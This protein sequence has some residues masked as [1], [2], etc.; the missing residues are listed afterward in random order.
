MPRSVFTDKSVSVV[1]IISQ[2]PSMIAKPIKELVNSPFADV[3]RPGLPEEII[4]ITPEMVTA[5]MAATTRMV[6]PQSR[7]PLKPTMRWQSVQGSVAP[8]PQ[9]TSPLAAEAKR[10]KPKIMKKTKKKEMLNSDFLIN[11]FCIRHFKLFRKSFPIGT[12][13]EAIVFSR[14]VFI[15]IKRDGQGYF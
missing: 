14:S 12:K 10:K 13:A 11:I 4:Y 5:V 3:I 6:I 8:V 1:L 2:A 9:G 7:R 15:N